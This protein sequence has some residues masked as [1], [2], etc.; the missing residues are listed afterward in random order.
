MKCRA[1]KSLFYP[2]LNVLFRL[3][4]DVEVACY[5]YAGIDAVKAAL[6]EGL[7]V[8]TEEMPIKVKIEDE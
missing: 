1:G 4:L 3:I 6:R 8:S 2:L 5:G 7:N